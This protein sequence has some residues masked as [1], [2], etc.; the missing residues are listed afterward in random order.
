MNPDNCLPP[1]SGYVTVVATSEGS[2]IVRV[3]PTVP[4]AP[5]D[6]LAAMPAGME[7][8]IVLTQGQVLNLQAQG[9]DLGDIFSMHV[10]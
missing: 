8:E 2:T 5:G 9:G 7:Q 3:T 4:V 1:Q 6:T 10:E